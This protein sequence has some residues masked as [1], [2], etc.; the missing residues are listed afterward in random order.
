MSSVY[1]GR[2]VYKWLQLGVVQCTSGDCTQ[3][4]RGA[5]VSLSPHLSH[6]PHTSLLLW[7]Q[8]QTQGVRIQTSL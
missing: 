3:G 7:W 4:G 8:T 1:N 6:L 2:I 5:L